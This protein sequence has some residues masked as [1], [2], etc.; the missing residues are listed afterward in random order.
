MENARAYSPGRRKMTPDRKFEIQERVVS[1][2]NGQ[3]VN[4]KIRIL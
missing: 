2:D 1:K 4:K 3:Y